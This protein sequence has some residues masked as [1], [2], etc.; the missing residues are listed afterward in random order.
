M[1]NN[2]FIF[3]NPAAKRL[4]NGFYVGEWRNGKRHGQGKY[5]FVNGS[6]YEGSFK[7]DKSDGKGIYYNSLSDLK[8][9][10]T[11]KAD[12]LEKLDSMNYTQKI[13]CKKKISEEMPGS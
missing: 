9:P 10:G 5:T 11:W 12:K 6:Y 8:C 1:K 4:K 13:R 3:I 7:N 2:F